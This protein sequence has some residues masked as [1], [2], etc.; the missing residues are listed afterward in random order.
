MYND[1]N[2]EY[3]ANFSL[4]CTGTF[5]PCDQY[6]TSQF[7]ETQAKYGNGSNCP[8][9]TCLPGE[10]LCPGLVF[11]FDTLDNTV[12][13]VSIN[14]VVTQDSDGLAVYDLTNSIIEFSY[15]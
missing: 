3:Y 14:N 4:D 15:R 7:T 9:K 6:C 13:N 5:D 12:T 1:K 10:D 11:G 2:E 8:V